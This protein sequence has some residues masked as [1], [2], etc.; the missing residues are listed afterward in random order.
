M[1]DYILITTTTEKEEDARKI[2][3]A[4]TEKRLSACVQIIGPITSF[5]WWKGKIEESREWLC[6]LKGRKDKYK[7]IEDA[8]KGIHPYEVPEIIS[9]TIEKGSASY[10]QWMEQELQ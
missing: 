10:M 6:L 1:T 4:L 8:I 5:Y 9:V 3:K 2:A 7:E